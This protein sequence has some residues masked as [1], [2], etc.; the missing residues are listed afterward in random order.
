MNGIGS[1]VKARRKELG[2]KQDTLCARLALVTD[3]AWN[4]GPKDVV[5]IESGTR[6]IS[7]LE[8]VAIAKALGCTA[9]WLLNEGLP[10]Q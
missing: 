4:P 2:W 3:Q 10:P 7:D 9:A 5:R 8:L 6:K 1:R